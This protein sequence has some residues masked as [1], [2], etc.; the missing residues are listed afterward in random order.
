MNVIKFPEATYSNDNDKV[1]LEAQ[2][3]SDEQQDSEDVVEGERVET[4]D[5]FSVL[6]VP[7]KNL[8]EDICSICGHMLKEPYNDGL[9]SLGNVKRRKSAV[10]K[11][12]CGH[13]FHLGCLL[14]YFYNLETIENIN[15]LPHGVK[16]TV[17]KKKGTLLIKDKPEDSATFFEPILCPRPECYE[18]SIPR[19]LKNKM[20]DFIG[21]EEDI[22][23]PLKE[24]KKIDRKPYTGFNPPCFG[25]NCTIA[26]SKRK[27]KKVKKSKRTKKKTKK[28]KQKL[29]KTKRKNSKK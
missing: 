25:I 2:L 10:L 27:M 26:G 17:V 4:I 13:I 7:K 11:L 1:P 28:R 3:I 23:T 16:G 19:I 14:D 8:D 5:N 18:L 22:I 12:I 29:N 9:V 21:D 24:W 20:L 6:V 15:N